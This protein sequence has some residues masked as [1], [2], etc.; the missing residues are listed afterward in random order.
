MD[1]NVNLL[2]LPFHHMCYIMCYIAPSRFYGMPAMQGR[3]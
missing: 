2:L 3:C 1:C